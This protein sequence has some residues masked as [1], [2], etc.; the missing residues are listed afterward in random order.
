M[1]P[2]L[3]RL[4]PGARI[5]V[6]SPSSPIRDEKLD[7]GIASLEQLGFEIELAPHVREQ[8]GYLAGPDRDR[9]ADLTEMFRRDDIDAVMCTRGGYGAAR[10]AEMVDWTI[11]RN[12]PKVFVG[13]SD[14]TILHLAAE[15]FAGLPT[16]HGPM[17]TT[18][19]K[20]MNEAALRSFMGAVSVAEPPGEVGDP[21]RKPRTLVAGRAIGRLAGG[22]LTLL[23]AALGTPYAPDFRDRIVVLED[24]D[25]ALYRVDRMLTQLVASRALREAS[26]FVIGTVSNLTPGPEDAALSL[27]D[28]W[29]DILVPLGKP[30]ITGFPIGHVDSP[31]TLPMGRMAE[32]DADSGRL[33][34]TEA[35]VSD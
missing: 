13:Y 12:H 19:A 5:G 16:F 33:T 14:I 6:V 29:R 23:C 7:A 20:P 35:C 17:V 22:C 3:R 10:M 9:A 25:E 34:I 32:L 15:R 18:F 11:V 30:A 28:L 24:T 2:C 21:E 4:R 27:D 31:L 1:T 26:A 8:W